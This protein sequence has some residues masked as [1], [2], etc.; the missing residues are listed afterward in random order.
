MLLTGLRPSPRRARAGF[1]EA[2]Q[3]FERNRIAMQNIVIIGAGAAGVSAAAALRQNGFDGQITVLGEEPALPYQR[4]PLSKVWLTS[5]D[6]P[7]PTPIRPAGF[8]QDNRITLERGRKVVRLDREARHVTMRDRGAIGYDKLI[9]AT[10]ASPRPIK[11]PGAGLK[12][13]FYLRDLGHAAALREA[14]GRADCRTVAIVG[15][16]VIGLE[17]GSAAIARGKQVTVVEAA[18]RPMARVASPA[19][20]NHVTRKLKA[21]GVAFIVNARVEEI[22]GRNGRVT[23]LRLVSEAHVPADIVVAGIGALPN[24]GLAVQAGLGCDGGIM[25]DGAMLTTDPHVYAVGDCA[26]AVT[27][28]FGAPIRIETIHHAMSQALVAAAH[29]CGKPLPPAA[30]SRF[31]S[32]L[33]GMK[34]QGLGIAAGYDR[35]QESTS[36]DDDAREIRLFSGDRL[37][38]AETVNLPTRQAELAKALRPV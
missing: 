14:L 30:P 2:M 7:R 31:W 19:V 21:E 8:F 27:P 23:G 25:V 22:M 6:T 10:G 12:N 1:C 20:T 28:F 17:V 24:V 11:V 5:A 34:V 33:K 15:G 38:A 4:P 9:L 37:A 13:V 32:D 35:L 29:I 26:R 18:A 3:Q 16:G 36:E